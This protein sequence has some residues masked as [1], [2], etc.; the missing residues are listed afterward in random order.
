MFEVIVVPLDGSELAEEALAKG[1]ELAGKLNSRLIL[2]QAVDS[3]AQRMAQA[4]AVLEAPSAAAASIE[5]IQEAL[6]A[7]KEA[8]EKYLA[9]KREQTV[10]GGLA[11]V[12][13]YVGEGPA[14]E[15]ILKLVEDKGA[16]LIVMS[17]H[18]RGGLGRLVFGSV[19]DA[20]LRHSMVPVLLIRSQQED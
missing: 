10:A 1:A 16:S 9:S 15:V 8:G 14:S 13:A 12:E 3:L 17:T 4:P 18:G 7:E 11:A 2:V 19:A 20:V 6:D 5:I